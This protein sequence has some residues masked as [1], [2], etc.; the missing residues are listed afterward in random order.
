MGRVLR[1][2]ALGGVMDFTIYVALSL[3]PLLAER[4]G[5][6]SLA[7]GLIPVAWGV[8]YSA[9][10][11]LGG[12][13]SDRISRTFLARIGLLLI[14]LACVLFSRATSA[15][16]VW[17]FYAGVPIVA[18]GMSLFWP[19]LQAAIADESRPDTLN[20]NLGWFNVSWSLGK[21]L[22]VLTGGLLLTVLG[23]DGFL[24]AAGIGVALFVVMPNVPKGAA[25]GTEL[26]AG[27]DLEPPRV[28]NA[29][30]ISALVA[31]FAAFGMGTAI[32]NHYP[33]WNA[34]LSRGGLSYGVVVGGIFLAQT[35]AFAV[36]LLRPG[37]QYRLLPHLLPQ[38]LCA[39]GALALATTLP[40]LALLPFALLVGW[41]FGIAYYSSIY[42]SLHADRARGG[43]A[44]LHEAVLGTGHVVIPLTSGV[45]AQLMGTARAPY[46]I[47]AGAV[48]VCIAVQ[49]VVLRR[50]GRG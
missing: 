47:A 25:R 38:A 49:V 40:V 8:T 32:I 14:V 16:Y 30:W 23:S 28:R 5:A 3:V 29:Y 12:R 13:I 43:R 37:W 39:V 24:V 46:F 42:Y 50:A 18:L 45:T 41:G 34:E 26:A 35:L 48:L 10:A 6:G 2:V 9:T 7:L 4:W 20:R 21:G 15:T 17:L 44:G 1:Y 11:V 31:N 19:A 27:S 36:L 33:E 22:G